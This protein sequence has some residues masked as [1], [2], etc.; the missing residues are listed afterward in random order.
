MVYLTPAMAKSPWAETMNEF[1]TRT[2]VEMLRTPCGNNRCLLLSL[3]SSHSTNPLPVVP[4]SLSSSLSNFNWR[5]I[6]TLSLTEIIYIFKKKEVILDPSR[7][8]QY[9]LFIILYRYVFHLSLSNKMVHNFRVCNF[10]KWISI[11]IKCCE[12]YVKK[13]PQD[14][15][16]CDSWRKVKNYVFIFYT[17]LWIL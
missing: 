16:E 10:N 12:F 17:V 2:L 9:L 13:I 4:N 1:E 3:P 14:S 11:F 7:N 6:S 5:R 8:K 15:Y